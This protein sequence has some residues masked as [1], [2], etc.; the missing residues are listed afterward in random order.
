[1]HTGAAAGEMLQMWTPL[2]L[3]PTPPEP[4]RTPLLTRIAVDRN[5]PPRKLLWQNQKEKVEQGVLSQDQQQ[6]LSI[7]RYDNE[8]SATS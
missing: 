5:S 2:R 7:N 1:M 6:P 4:A 3:H 8:G